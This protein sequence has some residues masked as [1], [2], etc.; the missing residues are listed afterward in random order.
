MAAHGGA[1]DEGITV[2]DALRARYASAELIHR[3]DRATSGVMLVAKSKAAAR[4]V[5]EHWADVTKQYLAV[6]LGDDVPGRLDAKLDQDGRH[7]DALTECQRI[8]TLDAI[9]P[10]SSLLRIKLVTGRKHQI[11]RHLAQARHPVLLDDKYGD[12]S[13]NK[14]WKRAVKA[15]GGRV[16]RK[17][18]MLHAWRLKLARAEIVAPPPQRWREAIE[19]AGGAL[20]LAKALG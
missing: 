19:A 9:E 10:H 17:G 6:A 15:A 5:G 12:F 18:L 2:I 13:A 7:V 1:G 16:P 11:R 20:P 4:S 8:A 14:S 3:L